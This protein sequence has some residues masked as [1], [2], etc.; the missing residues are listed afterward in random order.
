MKYIARGMLCAVFLGVITIGI[1]LF[2]GH[3]GAAIRL[4]NYVFVV[5]ISGLIVD[6]FANE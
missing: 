6:F 1:L 5:L 2:I 3:A 4:S